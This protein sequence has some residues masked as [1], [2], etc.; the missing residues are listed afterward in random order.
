[1]KK[2]L[3][4]IVIVLFSTLLSFAH[5]I[6]I[7]GLGYNL[8]YQEKTAEVVWGGLDSQT[9]IIIPPKLIRGNIEYTITSI[10]GGAFQSRY[11]LTHIEIP[12]TVT[13]IG[14]GAFNYCISLTSVE[15]P[16]SVTSIGADAFSYCKL[17][18]DITIPKSITNIGAGAFH[19][20]QWFNN[21]PEGFVY[22]NNCLYAYRGKM[23]PETHIE[24]REGTTQIC[25]GGIFFNQYNLTSVHIPNSV[26]S[27]G[28]YAF[29]GTSITSISI[30]NG[31]KT[32]EQGT[33]DHCQLLNSVSIPNSI[34]SIKDNA[35][36][37]CTSLT[38]ITIPN[39]VVTLFT[40]L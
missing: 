27:I 8:N 22:I 34:T 38:S 3:T 14:G 17:L 36:E 20:T 19:N 7:D 26:T 32:I 39:S 28:D 18:S 11:L 24:I 1:M 10:G 13:S 35:F 23:Q 16:E 6:Q 15:I 30:P 37:K 12:N 5:D 21:Q 29:A 25:G 2:L 4:T 33:F 40:I 9:S 31:V